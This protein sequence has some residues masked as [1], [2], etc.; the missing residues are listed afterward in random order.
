M[1]IYPMRLKSAPRQFTLS[2]EG[3]AAASPRSPF[4]SHSQ[5]RCI[6]SPL[7]AT[8]TDSTTRKSFPCHSYENTRGWSTQTRTAGEAGPSPFL[9]TRHSPLA[10]NV[11]PLESALPRTEPTTP[12]ES[13]LT[14]PDE[15]V[16]K[17]TTLT[18]LESALTRP[19]ES[20]RKQRTSSLT[21]S[22]LTQFL[23]ISPL[24]SALTKNRGEG[25]MC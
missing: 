12:A 3:S 4:C 13:T 14:G 24:E 5:K 15:S 18:P 6:L 20:D 19:H 11:T 10:T 8:L 22:T 16:S 7:F 2:P 17:Q 21:E 25:G 1:V 9:V 23:S